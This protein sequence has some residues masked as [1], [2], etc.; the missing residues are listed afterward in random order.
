MNWFRVVYAYKRREKKII[1]AEIYHKSRKGKEGRSR[2]SKKVF[3]SFKIEFDSFFGKF[4]EF[5]QCLCL[6]MSL[7]E[8][9]RPHME[10]VG[11]KL[12]RMQVPVILLGLF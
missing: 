4:H 12:F 2:I 11:I 7:L 9:E 1:F 10:L 8:H 3:L 6:S 5:T